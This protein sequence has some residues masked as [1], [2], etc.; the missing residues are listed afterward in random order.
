M[1]ERIGK[2]VVRAGDG[3]LNGIPTATREMKPGRSGVSSVSMK[4]AAIADWLW[5]SPTT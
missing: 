5:S 3:S 2:I 1:D 4:E